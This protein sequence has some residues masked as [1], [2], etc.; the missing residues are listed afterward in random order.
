MRECAAT[1]AAMIATLSLTSA[2]GSNGPTAGPEPSTSPSSHS[3][4]TSRHTDHA[5]PPRPV[6]L[7]LRTTFH[8]NHAPA[9]GTFTSSGPGSLCPSG[10]FADQPVQPL[11][12]GLVLNRTLT[13]PHLSKSVEIRETIHFQK[14]AADGSQAT[15]ETWRA[16]NLGDGMKGSGH[17]HGVATGC[18]PVGSTFATSCAHA[19]GVLIGSLNGES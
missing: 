14:V 11:T 7:H 3:H 13:C 12:N 8:L 5:Q 17:G 15:T 9:T 16:I 4:P 10:T 18:T 1:V 19:T 6:T 2:C